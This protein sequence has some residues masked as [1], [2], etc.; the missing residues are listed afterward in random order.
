MTVELSAATALLAGVFY[1]VL[2]LTRQRQISDPVSL[3]LT[4]AILSA[5]VGAQLIH[6][7]LGVNFREEFH[8]LDF[9]RWHASVFAPIPFWISLYL[10]FAL[11]AHFLLYATGEL[12]TE[13]RGRSATRPTLLSFASG[14]TAI[15]AL[16][17]TVWFLWSPAY[18]RVEKESAR[19][20][21]LSDRLTERYLTEWLEAEP[22]S[23]QA[24]QLYRVFKEG[25]TPPEP[26]ELIQEE[27]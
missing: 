25:H 13:I 8:L 26:R 3:H 11:T 21:A 15:A 5:M 4:G 10:F 1:C 20:R 12:I 7:W 22:D 23:P 17:L 24:R 19:I 2:A 14:L 27:N 6:V 16:I 9:T 18:A